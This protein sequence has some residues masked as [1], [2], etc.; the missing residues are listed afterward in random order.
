MIPLGIGYFVAGFTQRKQAVHDF[1]ANTLV[2]H[3]PG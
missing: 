3:K 1:L 2:L